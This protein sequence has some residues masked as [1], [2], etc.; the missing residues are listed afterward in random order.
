MHVDQRSRVSITFGPFALDG[1]ATQLLRDGTEVRLRPQAM[2]VLKVLLVHSGEWVRYDQMIAEAWDGTLVSQHTVDVTVGEV[3]R[4]LHEYG[5]WISNRPKVGYSLEVPR[6]DELVRKG[7]HFWNQRTREGLEGGRELRSIYPVSVLDDPQHLAWVREWAALGERQRVVEKVPSEYAVLGDVA[8]ISAPTWG[9]TASSAVLI[10]MPLL[11]AAFTAVFDDAW[12][13]GIAVPD[14]DIEQDPDTR[15]LSLL[16]SGFKDEAIARYLG[17][18]VRTVR[19]RVAGLMDDLSVHSR[20]QLG[21]VAE[22]RGLLAG[23]R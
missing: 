7:W 22:R 16:A 13:G 23:R 2:R 17:I 15:L 20:F 1:S 4:S 19:R 10:R 5:K 11:V 14:E 9:G 21:V 6:S 18:G 12:A 3:K 8:V